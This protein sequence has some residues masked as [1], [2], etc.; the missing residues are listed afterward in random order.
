MQGSNDTVM[1]N[2][3]RKFS[4]AGLRSRYR[5]PFKVPHILFWN[6]RKTDGFPTLSTEQ[7]VTMLSGYNP[8]L[9][10]VFCEKGFDEL[11]NVTPLA[12]LKNLLDKERYTV[13]DNQVT[14]YLK[15]TQ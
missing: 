7:N 1:E 5:T 12:M 10:N 11:K 4:E 13:F 14:N 6:L 9:L 8:V 15:D 3:K 2:I